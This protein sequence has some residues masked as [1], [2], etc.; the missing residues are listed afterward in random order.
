MMN[1][2]FAFWLNEF[3]SLFV[4]PDYVFYFQHRELERSRKDENDQFET[5]ADEF[6]RRVETA[7][8]NLAK[9]ENFITAKNTGSPDEVLDYL[10]TKII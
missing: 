7:Y 1:D 4:K 5:A 2:H 6:K 3:A 8:E 9:T 10:L